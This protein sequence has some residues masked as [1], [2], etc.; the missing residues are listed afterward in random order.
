MNN[1]DNVEQKLAEAAKSIREAA[2]QFEKVGLELDFTITIK[3]Q[4]P[5]VTL[6]LITDPGENTPP[7]K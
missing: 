6:S 2:Q 3:A 1:T 5:A 7:L 4:P